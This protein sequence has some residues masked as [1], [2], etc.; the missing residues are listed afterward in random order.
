MVE[1]SLTLLLPF[2]TILDERRGG[3]CP[4]YKCLQI[5]QFDFSERD[6]EIE[7]TVKTL[8]S[9]NLRTENSL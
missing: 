4:R 5:S 3:G 7:G 1:E 6:K 8:I 2:V 9:E